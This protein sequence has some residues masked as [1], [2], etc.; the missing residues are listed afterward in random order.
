MVNTKTKYSVITKTEKSKNAKDAF[1]GVMMKVSIQTKIAVKT[2]KYKNQSKLRF[3]AKDAFDC[4]MMKWIT[5]A[6]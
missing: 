1:Y 4:M 6:N 5:D 3:N 2:G